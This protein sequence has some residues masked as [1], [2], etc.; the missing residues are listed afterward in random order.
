MPLVKG[1]SARA[2]ATNLRKLKREG[3]PIKQAI[4]IAY[5]N[6]RDALYRAG[7]RES[8]KLRD[9]YKRAISRALSR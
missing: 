5:T 1:Y 8:A 7:K 6:A 3:R 9:A 4:A 2:F